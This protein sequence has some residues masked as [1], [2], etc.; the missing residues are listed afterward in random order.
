MNAGANHAAR[1][2]IHGYLQALPRPD[3]T[4]KFYLPQRRYVDASA[5]KAQ[6]IENGLDLEKSR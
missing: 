2:D 3:R 1:M 4:E 5:Q 6:H